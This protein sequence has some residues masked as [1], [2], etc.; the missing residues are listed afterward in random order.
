M[1]ATQPV[2]VVKRGAQCTAQSAQ[3]R[4]GVEI[5]CWLFVDTQ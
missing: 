4:M 5:G 3:K 1:G 2:V